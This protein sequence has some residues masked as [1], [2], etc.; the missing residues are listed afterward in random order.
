MT[1]SAARLCGRLSILF[2]L[3]IG[4]APLLAQ[5]QPDRGKILYTSGW[6]QA[7]QFYIAD[8]DS[9]VSLSLTRHFRIH[10]LPA[11]APDGQQIA[12][13]VYSTNVS[14]IW[15][16]DMV[17]HTAR[18]LQTS[19]TLYGVHDLYWSSDS[20]K[21]AFV[22]GSNIYIIDT[23]TDET[24]TFIKEPAGAWYPSWSPDGRYIAFLSARDTTYW[25][26]YLADIESG[27]MH[28]LPCP[29]ISCMTPNW[30]PDGRYL[31]FDAQSTIY[32]IDMNTLEIQR[33]TDGQ[34]ADASW[35]PLWSPDNREILFTAH[36]S[37]GNR[38]VYSY[39]WNNH[40]R[41]RLT[42]NP[43]L[44]QQPVWSPDGNEIAFISDRSG[45]WGIYIMDADGH[46]VRLL[47]P[48]SSALISWQ[49]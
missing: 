15:L 18:L 42:D 23:I 35:M 32:T 16:A 6:D 5:F 26:I 8:A 20:R 46:R 10:S 1:R 41:H 22:A 40:Q 45:L 43:A 29:E 2:I 47:I 36:P 38:D 7:T 25:R 44:D 14:E 37:S 31:T 9:G 3:L 19:H 24:R 4:A 34:A 48:D 13:V 27:D 21:L 39:D 33:L 28:L 12:W 11:L 49:P 17:S 30:S